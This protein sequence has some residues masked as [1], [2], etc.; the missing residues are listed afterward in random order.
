MN[1]GYLICKN[2]DC[3]KEHGLSSV[4]DAPVDKRNLGH[5]VCPKSIKSQEIVD[6]AQVNFRDIN[7]G[8]LDK[9]FQS[10]CKEHIGECLVVIPNPSM[11]TKCLKYLSVKDDSVKVVPIKNLNNAI[12][13]SSL[14]SSCQSNCLTQAIA[15]QCT[16]W[17]FRFAPFWGKEKLPSITNPFLVGNGSYS[18]FINFYEKKKC[19]KVWESMFFH[20][21]LLSL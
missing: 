16:I 7:S 4:A 9:C 3:G 17:D 21:C 6:E 2:A 20:L 11:Q 18:G 15:A 12:L 5:L 14:V 10:L 19:G 8:P 13:E 1:L